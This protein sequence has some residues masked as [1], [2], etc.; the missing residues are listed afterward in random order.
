ME[1]GEESDGAHSSD[2]GERTFRRLSIKDVNAAM[3]G[4][5]AKAGP[6]PTLDN[7]AGIIA[8]ERKFKQACKVTPFQGVIPKCCS[9]CTSASNAPK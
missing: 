2:S 1:Q 8:F 4:I 3:D 6:L 9:T 7:I 5:V